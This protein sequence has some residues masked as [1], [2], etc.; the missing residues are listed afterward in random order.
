MALI[1]H[2]KLRDSTDV[3][4]STDPYGRAMTTIRVHIDSTLAPATFIFA[5]RDFGPRRVDIFP[6][7]R[8]EHFHVHDEGGTTAD[9]TEGTPA[10]IGVNWERC[11]YDWSHPDRVIATVT[12]SNVYAHPGSVWELAA[13]AAPGGSSVEMTWTRRFRRTPRGLIFGML[14]KVVGR[15]LFRGYAREVVQNIERLESGVPSPD[16]AAPPV[17]AGA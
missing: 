5:A 4:A 10:G 11:D 16:G 12:G 2:V 15:P 17:Q 6:A 14:F 1:K 7:V 3:G 8:S 13:S 9:V